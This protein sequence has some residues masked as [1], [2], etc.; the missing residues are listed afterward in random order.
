MK[1]LCKTLFFTAAATLALAGN[2]ALAD[3]PKISW[4]LDDA[5][6]QVDRQAD[7]FQTAMARVEVVRRDL[8]GN[9][10]SRERGTLFIDRKGRIRLDTDVPEQRT[11]LVEKSTLYIHYPA[12]ERVEIYSLSKHKERIEPFMRLG[13]TDSGKDLK[14]DYLLTSLG[15]RDIGESRS[16]GLELTP[17]KEKERAVMGK[18]QLWIDQASW[19]PVQQVFTASSKGEEITLTYSFVARN[20]ELNPDLFK[21]KWPRGTDKQKMK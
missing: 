15:E 1:N 5:L 10:L 21:T 3:G 4:D 11:Y 6:K 14:D 18:A 17:E 19:M 12:Q 9:E 8:G 20:L 7:D 13:F 16:L 2:N